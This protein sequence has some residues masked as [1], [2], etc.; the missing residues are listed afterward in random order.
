MINRI[1]FINFSVTISCPHLKTPK[2]N[3]DHC[4]FAN[5][6]IEVSLKDIPPNA[7]KIKWIDFMFLDRFQNT[8]PRDS[9]SLYPPD[10]Q[11]KDSNSKGNLIFFGKIICNQHMK[12]SRIFFVMMESDIVWNRD[13]WKCN[14]ETFVNVCIV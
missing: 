2:L 12:K 13:C 1:K 4:S 9:P 6:T 3:N 11:F 7:T 10:K 14:N 5:D 8:F